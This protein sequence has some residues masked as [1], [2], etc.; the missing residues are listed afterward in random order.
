M[1]LAYAHPPSAPPLTQRRLLH[2][3]VGV[4]VEDVETQSAQEIRARAGAVQIVFTHGGF[5]ESVS[6]ARLFLVDANQ[7]LVLAGGRDRCAPPPGSVHGCL[8]ITLQPG[9]FARSRTLPQFSSV[10]SLGDETRLA[11]F[12]LL[13]QTHSP[14]NGPDELLTYVVRTILSAP[15]LQSPPTRTVQIAQRLMQEPDSQRYSLAE[16]AR[17]VGVTPSHLTQEFT[18]ATGMSL[19]QYQMRLR[20]T[21]ALLKLP[22]CRDI[23]ELALALGFSSHSHFSAAFKALFGITPSEFRNSPSRADHACVCV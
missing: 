20:I 19:Y 14:K 8:L 15:P 2:R 22:E 12:R 21:H 1:S 17:Q 13:H 4:S 7:T 10:R 3:S 5:L 16:I 18:R 9:A 11:A 23:T 6:D